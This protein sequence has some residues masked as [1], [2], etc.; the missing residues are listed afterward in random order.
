MSRRAVL[1]ACLAV[2]A[3]VA[4]ATASEASP[5]CARVV[6]ST[7]YA[8]D[9]TAYCFESI[10]W[11]YDAQRGSFLE[12][13]GTEIWRTTTGG[14]TWEPRTTFVSQEEERGGVDGVLEAWAISSGDERGLYLSTGSGLYVSTDAAKTYHLVDPQAVPSSFHFGA[15]SF[16]SSPL[17][18]FVGTFEPAAGAP[19]VAGTLFAYAGD[20][21]PSAIVDAGNDLH[22]PVPGAGIGTVQFLLPADFGKTGAGFALAGDPNAGSPT[23]TDPVSVMSLYACPAALACVQK[24]TTFPVNRDVE[25]IWLAPDYAKSK[26]MFA[27]TRPGIWVR[28]TGGARRD[29]TVLESTDGGVSFHTWASADKLLAKARAA[30]ASIGFD[31]AIGYGNTMYAAVAAGVDSQGTGEYPDDEVFRSTDAGRSWRRV[32]YLT[33]GG[34]DHPDRGNLPFAPA[35]GYGFYYGAQSPFTLAGD[36]TL[37]GTGYPT[38]RYDRP[39]AWC[40]RDGGVRWSRT[41]PR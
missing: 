34:E 27:L 14:R 18:P 2:L 39:R 24:L 10:G 1:A 15:Y 22:V 29:V 40:S 8:K 16:Q 31:L 28:D 38:G 33:L 41:C 26:R 36:G 35:V 5:P 4:P 20:E 23:D 17:T 37:F 11:A 7:A 6:V 9:H 3:P 12:T 13:R 32:A 21:S 19:T 30:K 25:H